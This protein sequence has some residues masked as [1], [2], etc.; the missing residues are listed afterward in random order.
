MASVCFQHS[1]PAK[2]A[3]EIK[4]PALRYNKYFKLTL[5]G[6]HLIST[7]VFN[8]FIHFVRDKERRAIKGKHHLKSLTKPKHDRVFNTFIVPFLGYVYNVVAMVKV[9]YLIAG[10]IT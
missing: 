1:F 8:F 7:G 5:E 10:R 6:Q 3:A 4:L 2:S 9:L